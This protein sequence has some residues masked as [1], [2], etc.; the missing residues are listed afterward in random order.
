MAKRMKSDPTLVVRVLRVRIKDKHASELRAAAQRVNFVWNY[1]NDL[2]LRIL[3]REQRFVDADELHRYTAGATK[4]GLALHSQS[5]QAV[6]E[7]FATR[8]AHAGKARLRWR[9]SFGS[10]RSLGWIPFKESAVQYRGGQLR[11]SGLP[12]P[13]SLWDSY[14]LAEY[15]LLC[16]TLSEDSRGRWYANLTVKLVKPAMPVP[17]LDR[18]AALGIDLG[19]KD[20]AAF[21]DETLANIEAPRFYRGLEDKLATAQRA[22]QSRRAK[23]ISAKIAN[24]RKDFLHQLSSRLVRN[25]RFL[26]IGDV[27][28]AALAQ[29]GL[30]K[31]VL[32]A[33]WSAFRDMLRYK[34]DYASSVVRI[35]PERNSTRECACCGELTGPTGLAGLAMRHWRCSNC[36]SMHN[37]DRNSAKVIRQRGMLDYA[38]EQLTRQGAAPCLNKAA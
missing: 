36:G 17:D 10:R 2:S 23:A 19:L 24:R 9:T 33:G 11:V 26:F 27:N 7:E 30:A 18:D 21:S 38:L 35:T 1:C 32:D 34:G 8:R 31:S 22:N 12:R 20:L 14:G 6:N 13:L 4:E 5:V 16:G 25:Y 3:Q 37:R 28:A 29:T 15:R